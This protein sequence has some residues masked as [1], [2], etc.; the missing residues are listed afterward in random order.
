[1]GFLQIGFTEATLKHSGTVPVFRQL[2][3]II[4]RSEIMVSKICLTK[5]DGITS[6]REKVDFSFKVISLHVCIKT[7]S[8]SLYLVVDKTGSKTGFALIA[9]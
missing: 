5:R 7:N 3:M 9:N 8:N 6:K 1:M 4:T 2:L